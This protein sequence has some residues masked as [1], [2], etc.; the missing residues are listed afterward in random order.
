MNLYER[1]PK[2]LRDGAKKVTAEDKCGVEERLPQNKMRLEY[3][4]GMKNYV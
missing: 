1:L 4:K 2:R 3:K